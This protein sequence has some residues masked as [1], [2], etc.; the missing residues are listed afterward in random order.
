M[1]LSI[2]G[3]QWEHCPGWKTL[4]NSYRGPGLLSAEYVAAIGRSKLCLGLLSSLNRDLHTTRSSEVP[5]AGGLLCAKHTTEH[6]AMYEHGEE[7]MFWQDA[8]QC[9]EQCRELLASPE[10]R[11]SIQAAGSAKVRRLGVGH[12]PVCQSLLDQ[13]ERSQSPAI[14]DL[15]LPPRKPLVA[16]AN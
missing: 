14:I 3:N 11:M 4:K 10:R 16:A 5:Y 13:I 2:W 9:V 15:G 12:E 8:E 1:P 6:E 7:A